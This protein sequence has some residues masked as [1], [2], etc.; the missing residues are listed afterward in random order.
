MSALGLAFVPSVLGGRGTLER[1][2]VRTARRCVAEGLSYLFWGRGR[3]YVSETNL[4]LGSLCKR[5]FPHAWVP[6]AC[7]PSA[8]VWEDGGAHTISS[9]SCRQDLSLPCSCGAVL[10]P[11][12]AARRPQD[13]LVLHSPTPPPP[14]IPHS[15]N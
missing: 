12:L 2:L 11:R 1:C 9:L 3:G 13:S 7:L 6:T 10:E 14:V 8:Q 15:F 5:G 4:T